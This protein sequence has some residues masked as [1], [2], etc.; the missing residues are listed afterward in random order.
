MNKMNFSDITK[1]IEK[2]NRDNELFESL[3]T[4]KKE[5]F[6]KY[7]TN[8]LCFCRLL[9]DDMISYKYNNNLVSILE[10]IDTVPAINDFNKID[11]TFYE[12]CPDNFSGRLTHTDYSITTEDIEN[13]LNSEDEEEDVDEIMN[14]KNTVNKIFLNFSNKKELLDIINNILEKGYSPDL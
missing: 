11:K 7:D 3:S 1:I 8:I 5:R 10:I 2:C 13:I 9:D 4:A 14:E 6:N 12:S